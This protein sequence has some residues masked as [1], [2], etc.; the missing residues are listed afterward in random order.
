MEN[1]DVVERAE[2][3]IVKLRNVGIVLTEDEE[4]IVRKCS[5]LLRDALKIMNPRFIPGHDIEHMFRVMEIAIF[6]QRRHGGDFTKIVLAALF[7]DILRHEKEHAKKSAGFAREYLSHTEFRDI[8]DDVARIIE[9]HSYSTRKNASSIESM[10][11][12]DADRLDA[13]GAIG[14][15]RVFSY[16]AHLGRGLY[17]YRNPRSGG[18]IA[19]FFEKI[20]KLPELMNTETAK[21]LATRRAGVVKNFVDT[22]LRELY[23]KDLA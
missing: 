16:S 20:L 10:I 19:H 23:L 2:F 9:E 22:F 14:V 8:A 21:M 13:L 18:S 1:I 4:E 5:I 17:N 6:L 7:H 3:A 11:L 12:Q 15:A